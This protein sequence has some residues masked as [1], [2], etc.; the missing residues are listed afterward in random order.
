MLQGNSLSCLLLNLQDVIT[1]TCNVQIDIWST[2]S[3]TNSSARHTRFLIWLK[4][5]FLG[6]S[7]IFFT[8]WNCAPIDLICT[9]NMFHALQ[10]LYFCSCNFFFAP[11]FSISPIKSFSSFDNPIKINPL[12]NVNWY[13]HYGKQYEGTLENYT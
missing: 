1:L 5:N 12:W 8:L 2:K 13:N 10:P 7:H 6:F 11:P 3:H 9:L 4:S